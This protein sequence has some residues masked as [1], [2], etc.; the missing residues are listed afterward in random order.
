MKKT[1]AALSLLFAA[2]GAF[3]ADDVFTLKGELKDFGD[4]VVA[5][6]P[7]GFEFQRDTILV[8]NGKFTTTIKVDEP[9]DIYLVS[10]NS[11][12]SSHRLKRSWIPLQKVFQNASKQVK[13]AQR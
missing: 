3:A 1:I 6:I 5:M 8:K 11:I 7:N 2:Q 12:D 4:T 10:V 13:N 9:K